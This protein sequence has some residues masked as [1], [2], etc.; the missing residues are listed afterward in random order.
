MCTARCEEKQA[1]Q[2]NLHMVRHACLLAAARS[3]NRHKNRFKNRSDISPGGLPGNLKLD[4]NRS[5]DL[6]RTPLA[7]KSIPKMSRERLGSIPGASQDVLG[8]SR[9]RPESPQEHLGMPKRAT[10]SAQRQ[11]K[12]TASHPRGQKV[13]LFCATRSGSALGENVHQISGFSQNLRTL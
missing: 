1:Q 8:T 5:R 10:G 2:L 4:K 11:P 12:S 13:E 7:P 9:E 3:H 6:L